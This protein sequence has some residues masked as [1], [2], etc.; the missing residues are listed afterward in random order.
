M[1]VS[2]DFTVS[3]LAAW[4]G[5]VHLMGAGAWPGEFGCQHDAREL[6]R[7]LDGRCLNASVQVVE[8]IVSDPAGPL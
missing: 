3:F 6:C 2:W 7:A 4:I 5:G 1:A 8:I